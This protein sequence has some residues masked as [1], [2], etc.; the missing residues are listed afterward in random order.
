VSVGLARPGIGD[1]GADH[2]HDRDAAEGIEVGLAIAQGRT[3]YV[4][5]SGM[6]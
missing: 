3:S 5:V 4:V 1:V 2:D 6:S